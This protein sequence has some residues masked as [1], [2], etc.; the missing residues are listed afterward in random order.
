[1]QA[2]RRWADKIKELDWL[3]VVLSAGMYVCFVLASTFGGA[4]WAW[5]SGRVIALIA[6]F[7]VLAAAFAASQV[8]AP[9]LADRRSQ[10]LFPV[11]AA[12]RL[13]PFVVI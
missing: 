3:G 12:V 4:A 6:G 1:M 9:L 2:D 7:V 10:R 5:S 8:C 13:L 11:E